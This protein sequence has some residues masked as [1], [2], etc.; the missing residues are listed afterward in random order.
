[1]TPDWDALACALWWEECAPVLPG[2]YFREECP[3]PT[4]CPIN[5]VMKLFHDEDQERSAFQGT[6]TQVYE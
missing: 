1:M 3:E 6:A 5:Q 4:D 2:C